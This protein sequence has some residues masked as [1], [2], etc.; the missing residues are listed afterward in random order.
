MSPKARGGPR[1]KVNFGQESHKKA[2]EH[3][4]C[5]IC[6][7][8]LPRCDYDISNLA[9]A[10]KNNPEIACNDC[11]W[12]RLGQDPALGTPK[13]R[14]Y[15][16]KDHEPL[17]EFFINLNEMH[18]LACKRVD[19]IADDVEERDEIFKK[20]LEGFKQEIDD[21]VLAAILVKFP[22]ADRQH[23][24]EDLAGCCQTYLDG[25]YAS[26][27]PADGHG[28]AIS[29]DEPILQGA[30]RFAQ[31]LNELI[32]SENINKEPDALHERLKKFK[33]LLS[34]MKCSRRRYC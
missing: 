27:R 1:A 13:D 23:A 33:E 31:F 25:V 19:E 18:D 17:K 26:L 2:T 12:K 11:S 34:H 32:S 29:G 10:K 21:K 4:R 14:G 7:R 28:G 3:Y 9:K 15:P 22:E 16:Q 20:S 24:S 6:Q 30:D 5:S 8:Q